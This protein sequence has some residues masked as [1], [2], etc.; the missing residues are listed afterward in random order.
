MSVSEKTC[1]F[2][3][4][5]K[6]F[7]DKPFTPDDLDINQL[8]DILEVAQGLFNQK[9]R[10][11]VSLKIKE[12]SA[13]ASFQSTE[14][15]VFYAKNNIT[16]EVKRK[17]TTMCYEA[18]L[19]LALKSS[20][21]DEPI[22]STSPSDFAIPDGFLVPGGSVLRGEVKVVGGDM[23]FHIVLKNENGSYK[24][25]C[26]KEQLQGLESNPLFSLYEVEVSYLLN[27]ETGVIDPKS[28]KLTDI[29]P[30][31]PPKDDYLE[32][33]IDQGSKK[34]KGQGQEWLNSIRYGEQSNT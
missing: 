1:Y 22:F 24:I 12:G 29:K 26:T 13:V 16:A 15:V 8:K 21:E 34:W 20:L 7:D 9:N 11:V 18:N 14:K 30:H 5:V 6:S 27:S 10:P 23:K 31:E 19:K 17:L 3:F 25:S 4:E 32:G 28:Y 2:N 33:L